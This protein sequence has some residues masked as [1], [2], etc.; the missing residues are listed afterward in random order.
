[1]WGPV[2]VTA[3]KSEKVVGGVGRV[4]RE[5]MEQKAIHMAKSRFINGSVALMI[6]ASDHEVQQYTTP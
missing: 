4:R 3:Y 5:P 2:F 6:A 1:M